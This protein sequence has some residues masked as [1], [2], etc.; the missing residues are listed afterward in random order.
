MAKSVFEGRLALV[1]GGSGGIGRAVAEELARRGASVIVHGRREPGLRG[2]NQSAIHQAKSP[3]T[4]SAQGQELFFSCAFERPS[5]FI[6]ALDRFLMEKACT[7]FHSA[8]ALPAEPDIVV[9][10]YGP[11]VEKPLEATSA[12]EWEHLALAN[13]ALPGALAS[14]FLPG[15]K[16][17]KF[18]RFLFFGGTRTDTIRPFRTTAAYASAKTGL[19]VLTKSLAV[20]GAADNVAAVLVCPGP[21]DTEYL[22]PATRAAHARLAPG[23]RL[24]P[25]DEIACAAIELLDADPCTASGAI[26]AFDGGFS[27]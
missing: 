18:G 14:R 1:I 26:L 7:V 6:H 23:G 3:S 20:S 19:G 13:L 10:S 9:C 5:S 2:Q 27:P 21:A 24:I 22:D 11:F 8:G 4:C 25:P 12:E 16:A 17:R 15:M